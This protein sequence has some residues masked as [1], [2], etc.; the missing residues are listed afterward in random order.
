[1][2]LDTGILLAFGRDLA[3][4]VLWLVLLS[5]LF[6][7]LERLFAQERRPI[8][9]PG[10][11]QDLGY[12]FLSGLLP[13]LLLSLPLAMMALLAHRLLPAGYLAMVTGLPLWARI[14]AG[15][16]VADIGAYWG[17]RLS[18]EIPLLWRFHAI[19]HSAERIDFLVNTRAHPVDL[20]FTRLCGFA[21]LYALGLANAGGPQSGLVP[22]VVAL[23][24]TV[25]AFFIHANLRWRFGVL[26]Q[27]VST[28][29]FH[30]WHHTRRDFVNRNYAATFPWIDRLFGTLHLPGHWPREY[31][32]DTEV[33][34]GLPAQLLRP[35]LPRGEAAEAAPVVR[36][37]G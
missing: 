37:E 15:I 25:W 17:H 10:L 22:V 12:F 30:H 6:L 24:G 32:T 16:V 2:P 11:W 19:H 34:E 31:G 13:K 28:P 20:L 33:G 14:L 23:I 18:H 7:P 5:S 36:V 4:L 1:M 27:L 29:A 26:E 9:R 21:P 3:R 8:R 35:L